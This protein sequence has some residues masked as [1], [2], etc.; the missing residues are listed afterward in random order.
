MSGVISLAHRRAEREWRVTQNVTQAIV[1]HMP[2]HGHNAAL[3][4][5]KI[6]R[7]SAQLDDRATGAAHFGEDLFEKGQVQSLGVCPWLDGGELKIA[8]Y[9][10]VVGEA[11]ALATALDIGF[12]YG[13]DPLPDA[14][15][16]DHH[17]TTYN[18]KGVIVVTRKELAVL[19][20]DIHER[21][22]RATRRMAMKK[23]LWARLMESMQSWFQK[24][25]TASVVVPL[26]ATSYR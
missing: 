1:C 23:P 12:V 4:A 21:I 22:A 16:Y 24:P 15:H 14:K 11:I 19:H 2:R 5:A 18:G 20:P 26:A 13:H 6:F 17:H 8:C 3:V 10:A 7:F 9:M 25:A